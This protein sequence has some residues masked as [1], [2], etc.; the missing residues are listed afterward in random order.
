MSDE[1]DGNESWT[2][3]EPGEARSLERR[4]QPTVVLTQRIDLG[5]AEIEAQPTLEVLSGAA[6]QQVIR[7]GS[8]SLSIGRA[9]YNDLVL[10]DEKVSRKHASIY[11]EKGEYLLEDLNSTNGV[12]LDG[13]R[14]NA[15]RLLSG[16]RITVGDTI[17][18]FTQP[19]VEISLADKIDF[20]NASDLF[21]WLDEAT[22]ELLAHSLLV[23]FFPENTVIIQQNTPVESLYFLYSGSVRV[24]EIND[25]GGERILDRLHPGDVFGERS[26]IAGESGGC[27]MVAST[28]SFVLELQKERLNELLQKKPELNKAFYRMLLKRL[29]AVPG[30]REE[31]R[32]D[33][34]RMRPSTSPVAVQI[35]GE[36]R[37]IKAAKEKL[38]PLAQ[39]GKSALILGAAGTGKKTFARY[40]HQNSP[41][42]TQP[43]V[44]ISL[45]ELGEGKAGAAI[46]GLEAEP[47]A[48][49]TGGELGYLEMIGPGT[50]A[51]A[52]AELLD[53]H[54]QSKLATYLK[55][56]WFHRV[57][58]RESVKARTRV[59]LLAVGTETE[60]L[61]RFIPELR[62]VF[63]DAVIALP[64]LMQRLKDIPTL[65]EHY[66]QVFSKREGK[67]LSGLSR[68]ALERLV[69]YSWPGN[70]QELEN[71]V[72]RA[73]IVA[74]EN[75]IIP[76]DLI[77]VIPSEKEV[78]KLNILR[79]DRTRNF[80]RHH[81][82]PNIF[83]WFNIV[84]VLLMAGFTL[85]GG[86]MAPDH[87][88]Q[89]FDNNP[90]MLITWLIWF[91]LL[92][93]SAFLVGRIWCGVCPIAGIG[94]LA[95]RVKFSLPVPRFLKRMD[96]W[97]VVLS[98]LFLDY[99]EEFLGVAKKPW[100]TGLLLVIIVGLSVIFCVLFERKTFCR[101]V[102]PL[103]GMLGAY[104]TMSIVEVRGNKKVCQT[105]CGEHSCY[106][107]TDSAPGC[108][109]FS[110]PASLSTNAECMMCLNC[111]KSCEN[112]GVQV[113]LR[114][115]LQE[116]WHQAQPMLSLSLFGVMLVG[117]MARHQFTDLTWWQAYQH[118]SGW[119]EG[120]THSVLYVAFLG[121]ALIPFLFSATLSAA[122]SQERLSENMAQYGMAFIP[123]ALSGHLAHVSHELLKE[124]LY[125]LV[126]YS[127]KLYDSLIG[128]IPIGSRKVMLTPF[129]D[130]AVATFIKFLLITGGMLGSLI[131]LVMIARRASERQVL[132]RILPY[133]LLLI[134]FWVGYLY[135]FLGR[136]G[137]AP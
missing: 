24:V 106:R 95:A 45:T 48:S 27:S 53:V 105:Q 94:A 5:G 46:F 56:G 10:H 90:G 111:V 49:Q 14:I 57:Y 100:A 31:E 71:V 59:L 112:R 18:L 77:F 101:Y 84:M 86:T 36:D 104:S 69:S 122:A 61:E 110:Y 47:G 81:L 67:R 15:A 17:L 96:F 64:S 130:P 1:R 52:H 60:V 88:L 132:G 70:V 42:P 121:F 136:T 109:M 117:L 85:F 13:D 7:L 131:A 65:A 51:I 12:Y 29:S 116:L 34:A 119:P 26:L 4:D 93:I 63:K 9:I 135:I 39:A 16:S 108:P 74:S 78:H 91:P 19:L 124:G 37:K 20:I 38:K 23:R 113:N 11:F 80:L 103:A 30:V 123:L 66:L 133:L 2:G 72:Q 76:G 58:G 98:F 83:I 41:D 32:V 35:V 120:L 54:Q 92:P 114:P 22:R 137:A 62:E 68:E 8:G 40:F 44:E 99:V 102:C 6:N 50:L 118:A 21:N 115:P 33:Q 87:P 126:K 134:F 75:L 3:S 55:Y 28:D 43:Y 89:Q 82:V 107:G 73:V 125:E 129:I 128:G 97:M 25:E 127:I 79:H